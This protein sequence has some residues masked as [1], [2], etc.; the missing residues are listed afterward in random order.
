MGPTM[1][2]LRR[3]QRQ[4]TM[5]VQFDQH[6]MHALLLLPLFVIISL[7]LLWPAHPAPSTSK[8]VY[9]VSI[10]DHGTGL[11]DQLS[12]A[13]QMADVA[14][15]RNAQFVLT[16][17]D[18]FYPRGIEGLD[19]PLIRTHFED[20]YEDKSLQIPWYVTLG[21]H[22]HRG[23]VAAQIAYSNYSS[24]WEMPAPYYVKHIALGEKHH[25]DLIITDSIGLEGA[26]AAKYNE[27]RRFEQDYSMEFAGKE[28]GLK[29][30]QWLTEVLR[31][32]TANWRVVVGHRPLQ[33]CGN[34]ARFPVEER[35]R[36]LL[37]P[38]FVKHRVHV[39]MHGHDHLG[40]HLEDEGVVYVGNGVGG[41]GTHRASA[42]NNT[43]WFSNDYLG[44][45]VHKVTPSQLD[46]KFKNNKGKTLH[47]IKLRHIDESD[48]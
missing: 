1:A 31:T 9:F 48:I 26:I 40:Q 32:S 47:Q 11:P 3:L 45:I 30:L 28:A 39:Y 19:D 4:L 18:N 8:T 46:F 2:R 12:V 23:S 7:C 43:I 14:S 29:Q 44:F 15:K 21:D 38:L 42:T 24:R 5:R 13:H 27:T 41:F 16:L 22:D 20:I 35:L 36:S 17:G 25:M 10:G 34:R 33:S 6:R 37:L